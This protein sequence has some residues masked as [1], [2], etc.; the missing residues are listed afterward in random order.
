MRITGSKFFSIFIILYKKFG[1]YESSKK[2]EAD[3]EQPRKHCLGDGEVWL[4]CR[5]AHKHVTIV[6]MYPGYTCFGNDR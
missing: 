3:K 5:K 4:T 6:Y 2:E 1:S